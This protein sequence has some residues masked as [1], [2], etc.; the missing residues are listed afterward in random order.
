ML[1][2][3]PALRRLYFVLDQVSSDQVYIRVQLKALQHLSVILLYQ[4]VP[5]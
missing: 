4:F 2:I 5:M 1:K 3:K